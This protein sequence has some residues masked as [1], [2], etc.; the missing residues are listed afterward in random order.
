MG[1][2]I[3]TI[4]GQKAKNLLDELTMIDP[5]QLSVKKSNG[6]STDIEITS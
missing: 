2:V 4:N 5:V 3:L 1:S 6:M